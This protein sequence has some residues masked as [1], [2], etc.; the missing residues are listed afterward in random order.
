MRLSFYWSLLLSDDLKVCSSVVR[1]Q[2]VD[3]IFACTPPFSL[4]FILW[5]M[6]APVGYGQCVSVTPGLL[7]LPQDLF[8]YSNNSVATHHVCH[9]HSHN[10][11]HE[12][13]TAH[14]VRP[15]LSL[16][17]EKK[18]PFLFHV[19]AQKK[20]NAR[21]RSKFGYVG[22]LLLWLPCSH[23]FSWHVSKW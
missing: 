15:F 8:C 11:R 1:R 19:I 17:E 3:R 13:I 12:L 14:S 21:S 16:L 7:S 18:L 23:S 22:H 10:T 4:C 9:N 6:L 5:N 20:G 2:L